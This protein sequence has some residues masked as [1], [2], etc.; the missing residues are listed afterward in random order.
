MKKKEL[1][2]K[3]L[4]V[5]I[6]STLL[7]TGCNSKRDSS[8]PITSIEDADLRCWKLFTFTGSDDFWEFA[9]EHIPT[10]TMTDIATG[11]YDDSYICIDVLTINTINFRQYTEFNAIIQ[12]ETKE[13]IQKTFSISSNTNTDPNI[14]KRLEYGNNI[15]ADLSKND[16]VKLCFKVSNGELLDYNMVAA[17]N[18]GPDTSSDLEKFLEKN[19]ELS[20]TLTASEFD[21]EDDL[22]TYLCDT[23]ETV[24]I[25]DIN[26]G[27]YKNSFV[28]INSVAL[29]VSHYSSEHTSC[30]MIFEQPDG[31]Y[32]N[33]DST[34]YNHWLCVYDD[35]TLKSIGLLSGKEYAQEMQDGDIFRSCVYVNS[36]NSFG[37]LEKILAFQKIGSLKEDAIETDENNSAP[38]TQDDNTTITS[39]NETQQPNTEPSSNNKEQQSNMEQSSDNNTQQPNTETE[40]QQQTSDSYVLNTSSMKI[41]RPSCSAAKKISFENYATS[42]SSISELESQGYSRCGICLK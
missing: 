33:M 30:Y 41:H 29:K 28:I 23:Y 10:V 39:N 27:K 13:Y 22:W 31:T 9:Y 11:S 1:I 40:S 34:D 14:G 21:T 4:V 15:F 35:D 36:D 42:N 8:E 38:E 37:W 18:L 26:S 12:D 16:K 17:K 25:D 2:R 20:K 24:T 7:L 5:L 6:A 3:G 32:K 19:E